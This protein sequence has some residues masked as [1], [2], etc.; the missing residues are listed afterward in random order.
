MHRDLS[1]LGELIINNGC[2]LLD[3]ETQNIED[4]IDDVGYT[5]HKFDKTLGLSYMQARYYDP[6]IG[7]LYGN[8]PVGILEHLDGTGGIQGFN[9]FGYTN[10]NP[11]RYTDPDGKS[12][13]DGD[14]SSTLA[15]VIL[16]FA[17][18]DE[19]K[20]NKNRLKLA[21]AKRGVW[22][23]EGKRLRREDVGSKL[24]VL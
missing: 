11:Y 15:G 23:R 3:L 1:S 20:N 5:G 17:L 24:E 14:S 8:D 4:E 22:E 7:R 19:H 2:Y 13:K 16:D 12:P 9:R 18:G 6:I 10:N 21:E